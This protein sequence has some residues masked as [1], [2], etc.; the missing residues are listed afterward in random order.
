MANTYS[1]LQ[2]DTWDLIAWRVYGSSSYTH[3]LIQ[4]NVEHVETYVFGPDVRLVVPDI[5]PA[6]AAQAN[7]P[8]WRRNR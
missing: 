8:P 1:T 4:A 5:T 2:G 3:V 7:T 6:E